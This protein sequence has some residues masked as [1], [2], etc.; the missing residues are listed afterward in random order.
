[1]GEWD[2]LRIPVVATRTAAARRRTHLGSTGD[3]AR[4]AAPPGTGHGS[5]RDGRRPAPCTPS[6][7][8]GTGNGSPAAARATADS[9]AA[10]RPGRELRTSCR[11]AFFLLM[12]SYQSCSRCDLGHRGLKI[13]RAQ[14]HDRPP[15]DDDDICARSEPRDQRSK[16]LTEPTL[17]P[18][19]NDRASD[20]SGNRKAHARWTLLVPSEMVHDET[21]AGH[22][23]PAP[24]HA[25]ELPR[26]A[27]PVRPLH[28]GRGSLVS[29]AT[30]TAGA[31]P[32][33]G[34][35]GS[36]RDRRGYACG[37][38]SRGYGC[39]GGC[40]VGMCASSG[41]SFRGSSRFGS[42]ALAGYMQRIRRSSGD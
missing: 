29:S 38:G 41:D 5:L 17:R 40:G 20:P 30:P 37:G 13:A 7:W 28:E 21:V 39:G 22:R 25:P 14:L 36:R 26:A 19:A 3:S 2:R 23:T 31:G 24:H 42:G 4:S 9:R 11:G 34:G 8:G 1:M 18:V 6:T 10:A 27:E 12:C 16:R 15:G 32:S 35:G 33:S